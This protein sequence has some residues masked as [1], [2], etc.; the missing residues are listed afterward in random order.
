MAGERVGLLTRILAIAG[1][2]VGAI[3]DELPD[4]ELRELLERLEEARRQ[5]QELGPL[6]LKWSLPLERERGTDD[7]P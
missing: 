1:Q 4:A 5:A 3:F 6:A 7:G 2:D